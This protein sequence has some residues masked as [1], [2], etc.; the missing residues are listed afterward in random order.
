MSDA[1]IT[2]KPAAARAP[3]FALM[4]LVTLAAAACGGGLPEAASASAATYVR[5]CGACHPPYNPGLLTAKMWQTMV[6]RME[7]EMGRRGVELPPAIILSVI[8]ISLITGAPAAGATLALCP[9]SSALC[10]LA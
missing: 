1:R 10:A 5:R 4:F 2:A 3:L 7:G 9:H 8:T 6:E